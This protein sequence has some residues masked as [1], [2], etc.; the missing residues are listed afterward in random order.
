MARQGIN[1]LFGLPRACHGSHQTFFTVSS[2]PKCR[3]VA[4]SILRPLH[5]PLPLPFTVR[6]A[7]CQNIR[8]LSSVSDQRVLAPQLESQSVVTNNWS[9]QNSLETPDNNFVWNPRQLLKDLATAA[10]LLPKSEWNPA[11]CLS[12][13]QSYQHHLAYYMQRYQHATTN[14]SIISD[15]ERKSLLS[16]Q[17][18]TLAVRCLIKSKVPTVSLRHHVRELER[19]LGSIQPAIPMTDPLSFVLLEANG[20]AGNVGR[21]LSLLELRAGYKAHTKKEFHHAVQAIISAGLEMRIFRSPY[22]RE[23]EHAKIDDPTRWLDSILVNMH[24]RGVPMDIHLAKS[25]LSTYSSTGMTGRAVHFFY[26]LKPVKEEGDDD[27]SETSTTTALS[28]T[29]KRRKKKVIMVRCE[30]P[31]HYKIPSQSEK[32]GKLRKEFKRHWSAPLTA[33]FAFANSLT[34]GACGHQPLQLDIKCWNMLI[35]ACCYRGALWRAIYLIREKIPSVGLTPNTFSYDLLLLG[36]AR[37]ADTVFIRE[38]LTEM[39]N[40]NIALSE[41][42]VQ[43]IVMG[44]LNAGDVGGSISLVQDIF[45]Q[46]GVLPPATS[47]LDIIEYA[48][49]N[50]LVFEAKRHVYFLQQVWRFVPPQHMPLNIQSKIQICQSHPKLRKEALQKLFEYHGETLTDADFM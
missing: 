18:A 2:H 44:Y 6:A 45:N 35:R 46:H 42:T 3:L 25:M 12:A 16:P 31:P 9:F 30:P 19:L 50:D 41:T 7:A 11:R 29:N 49:V 36:L 34:H 1:R 22:K 8:K 39:T 28:N 17:T 33:A 32:T 27:T 47:H 13:V 24:R 20:K 40:K 23:T 15:R 26:C 10:P 21:T 4:S 43:A 5:E 38:F 48:L 37:V 14:S